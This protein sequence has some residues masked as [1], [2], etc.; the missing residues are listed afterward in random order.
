VLFV[1]DIKR[2]LNVTDGVQVLP[3]VASQ[4]ESVKHVLL[5]FSLRSWNSW[6]NRV[7]QGVSDCTS[8]IEYLPLSLI[9]GKNREIIVFLYFFFYLT[10]LE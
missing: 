6:K 7:F 9:L 10:L 3:C 5:T 4:R 1:M 8:Q 2:R